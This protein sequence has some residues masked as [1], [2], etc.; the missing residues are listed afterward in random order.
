MAY[1]N[2]GFSKGA[3][4]LISPQLLKTEPN[5]L[6]MILVVLNTKIRHTTGFSSPQD[7]VPTSYSDTKI[8][9]NDLA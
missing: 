9:C 4:H 1:E 2:V 7:L 8:Y 6:F 3:C 5:H